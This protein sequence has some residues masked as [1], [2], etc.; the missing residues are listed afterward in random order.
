[1]ERV[2]PA[3]VLARHILIVPVIT[4]AQIQKARHLADSVYTAWKNGASFDTLAAK[5]SDPDEQKLVENEPLSGQGTP[6][7]PEYLTAVTQ[8]TTMG[9]KP[10]IVVGPNTPRP[11]F[12]II[13]VTG[14][15]A[16]GDVTFDDVKETIKS[17]VASDLAEAHYIDQLRHATYVD[18]RN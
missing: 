7:S 14:R 1:V 13:D 16:E 11:K 17:R 4:P 8:D 12:A 3:E 6:I 5:Y 9:I 2:Q 15:Q 10:V 18:V